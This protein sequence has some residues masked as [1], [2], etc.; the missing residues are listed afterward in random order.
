MTM[1]LEQWSSVHFLAINLVFSGLIMSI[2]SI[3]LVP[4]L[5]T[6]YCPTNF[7]S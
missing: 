4:R 1:S 3:P 5:A 7:I 2:T 6:A